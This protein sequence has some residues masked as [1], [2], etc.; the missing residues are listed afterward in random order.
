MQSA[1]AITTS[2]VRMR[3]GSSPSAIRSTAA[4]ASGPCTASIAQR[5]CASFT[6]TSKSPA[7]SLNQARSFSWFEAFVTVR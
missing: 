4:R 2:A 6:S 5:S 1:P 3:A 7:C